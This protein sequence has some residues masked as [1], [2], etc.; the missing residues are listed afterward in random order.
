M[1]DTTFIQKHR[2]CE[3]AF[4]RSRKLNFKT[5]V[6]FLLNHCKG[7]AQTELD[8]F[9]A[10]HPDNDTPCRHITKSACTQARKK[11]S[12][13]AFIELNH[14]FVDTLYSSKSKAL[15]R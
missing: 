6:T 13:E 3:T 14:Y 8:R 9:F 7:A 11:P 12:H 5:L 10:E 15:K 2:L 1:S 4:T